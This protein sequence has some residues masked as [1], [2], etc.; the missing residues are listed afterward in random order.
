MDGAV[1][2]SRVSK[3]VRDMCFG[4]MEEEDYPLKVTDLGSNIRSS[5]VC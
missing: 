4:C 1:R 2:S 5:K 3:G